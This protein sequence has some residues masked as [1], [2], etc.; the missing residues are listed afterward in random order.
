MESSDKNL[1]P[2]PLD[3]GA[4]GAYIW[5]CTYGIRT[6]IMC[7]AC[8]HPES[9]ATGGPTL[10]RFC[11]VLFFDKGRKDPK[12]HY[13]RAIVGLPAKRHLNGNS[14]AWRCWPNIEW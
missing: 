14:L 8:V 6:K 3:T 10:T 11:F 9:F 2:A 4:W 5:F 7:N 13:K 1:D 12:Y